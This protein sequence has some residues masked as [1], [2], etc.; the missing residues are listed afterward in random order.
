[1][2]DKDNW[3]EKAIKIALGTSYTG[4]ARLATDIGL[5]DSPTQLAEIAAALSDSVLAA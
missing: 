3:A 5:S 4:L 2:N 1:M